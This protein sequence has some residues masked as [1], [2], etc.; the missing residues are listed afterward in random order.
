MRAAPECSSELNTPFSAALS[1][2]KNIDVI[3][4]DTI[5]VSN[6]NRQFLFRRAARRWSRTQPRV[7]R[8]RP[9][10]PRGI[11]P[12][13]ARMRD[14]GKPKAVI[15]AERVMERVAGVVV[16]PHFCRIEEKPTDWQ[17]AA[18]APTC[19]ASPCSAGQRRGEGC[20][21]GGGI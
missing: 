19:A 14:V 13:H 17:A 11:A 4:M 9:S 18:D 2:I 8:R 1:G 15:A 6:L 20:A 16:T 3:D 5:D 12:R 10:N 21:G 7:R